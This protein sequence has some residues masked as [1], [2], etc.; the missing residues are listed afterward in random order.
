MMIKAEQLTGHIIQKSEKETFKKLLCGHFSC[1]FHDKTLVVGVDF[2]I[3]CY[4]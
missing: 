3:S 4:N 1:H 2:K